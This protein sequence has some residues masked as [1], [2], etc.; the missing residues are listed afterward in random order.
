[1]YVCVCGGVANYKGRDMANASSELCPEL[2]FSGTKF[3][4]GNIPQESF[5]LDSH[6]YPQING[7]WENHLGGEDSN[8]IIL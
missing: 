5:L 1:M 3:F 2:R 6:N 4:L 8:I 7:P